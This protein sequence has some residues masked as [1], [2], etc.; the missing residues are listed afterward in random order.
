VALGAANRL[1]NKGITTG[2]PNSAGSRETFQKLA[3]RQAG[4]DHSLGSLA[5]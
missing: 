2:Q 5:L 3:I 4:D 1:V